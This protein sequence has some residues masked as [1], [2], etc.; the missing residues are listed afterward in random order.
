MLTAV[1][2]QSNSAFMDALPG[3]PRCGRGSVSSPAGR[4]ARFAATLATDP[5]H[6]DASTAQLNRLGRRQLI[7][8]PKNVREMAPH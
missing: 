8:V 3:G 7:K 6:F 2:M 4:G 1:A 5:L